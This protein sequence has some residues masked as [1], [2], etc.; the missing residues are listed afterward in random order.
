MND[1]VVDSDAVVKIVVVSSLIRRNA[2]TVPVQGVSYCKIVTFICVDCTTVT[3]TDDFVADDM[4]SFVVLL[5][6]LVIVVDDCF[7]SGD[8]DD[9]DDD[10]CP[11]FGWTNWYGC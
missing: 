9:D 3:F 8:D 7:G 11:S 5:S 4:N 2:S 6:L 1:C 10:S